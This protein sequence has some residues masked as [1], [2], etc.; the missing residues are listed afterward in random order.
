[1]PAPPGGDAPSGGGPVVAFQGEPG[2]YSEAAVLAQYGSAALPLACPTFEAL[3]A[4][5]EAGQAD[6][7][8]APVENSLAGTVRESWDLLVAHHLPIVGEVLLPVRHCLLARHGTRLADVRRA[9][10]HPQALA[11]SAPFLVAHG[12]AP[13]PAYDT[14]GAARELAGRDEPGAAAIASARAAANYDLAVLADG[15]QARDDNTTRF[16]VI[17]REAPPDLPAEKATLVFGAAHRPGGLAAALASF[18]THGLNLLFIESRPTRETPWQYRFHVDL[19]A[20]GAP[21]TRERLAAL[22][23]DLGGEAVGARVL[24]V[25]PRASA[26]SA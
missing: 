2:A 6:C 26:G 9:Y 7:G 22:V 15:I 13:V 23:A 3:F 17:A 19:D 12:I 25:Y 8:M 24:G 20:G 4:A 5:V 11:Q 18:A 16:Y 1:M 21:I 10:S 14:A